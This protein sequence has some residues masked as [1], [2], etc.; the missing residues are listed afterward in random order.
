MHGNIPEKLLVHLRIRPSRLAH[1]SKRRSRPESIDPYAVFGKLLGKLLGEYG[2]G[3]LGS[4]IRSQIL[5][6]EAKR[7][8]GRVDDDALRVR[9]HHALGDGL[10]HIKRPVEIRGHHAVPRLFRTGEHAVPLAIF[11]A[12]AGVVHEDVNTPEQFD[13]LIDHA[14]DGVVVRD[15]ARYRTDAT[16][17]GKN[18]FECAAF[19]IN[20]GNALD[21]F[22]Q[23]TLD[24]A[25]SDPIRRP[26]HQHDLVVKSSHDTP[27]PH[28][29]PTQPA[30]SSTCRYFSS[31]VAKCR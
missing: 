30:S 10:R 12:D 23:E 9:L 13:H 22:G 1:A 21:P 27:L 8:R 14:M 3:R 31:A 7:V 6:N 19:D 25:A 24:H 15:V 28:R 11:H 5:R 17:I 26:S 16:L 20:C 18:V 2:N 29:R 4:G